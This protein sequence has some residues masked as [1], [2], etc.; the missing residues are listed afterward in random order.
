MRQTGNHC[1]HSRLFNSLLRSTKEATVAQKVKSPDV[2][3]AANSWQERDSSLGIFQL[4][5][6]GPGDVATQHSQD[7]DRPS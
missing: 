2:G 4:R 6:K 5:S 3:P 7:R 1:G